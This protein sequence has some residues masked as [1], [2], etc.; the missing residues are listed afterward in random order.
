MGAPAPNTSFL[1]F[2]IFEL[3]LQT[4]ELRKGGRKIRLRPQAARVLAVLAAHAGQLVSREQLKDEIWGQETFVDFE[5]GLNLCIGE[6]RSA[7]SDDAE[8]PR[9]IETLPRRGYR[10]M[11]PTGG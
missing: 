3:D 1:R 6:I 2:G 11:M 7:L 9:Y 8:T 10:F 5:H 4:G